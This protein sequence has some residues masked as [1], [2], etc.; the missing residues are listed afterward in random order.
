MRQPLCKNRWL[1]ALQLQRGSWSF[2]DRSVMTQDD[3]MIMARLSVIG[4]G[5]P[6]QTCPQ[7]LVGRRLTRLQL[8]NRR[9]FIIEAQPTAL[10]LSCS[11]STYICIEERSRGELERASRACL[12]PGLKM[13]RAGYCDTQYPAH[14]RSDYW[15]LTHHESQLQDKEAS[16]RSTASKA[17]S[18]RSIIVSEL[19]Q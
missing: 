8:I 5:Q 7:I 1:Q 11:H 12:D 3:P 9:A 19:F 2:V 15:P 6:S 10:V 13:L 16:S 17:S 4:P 14:W 18:W